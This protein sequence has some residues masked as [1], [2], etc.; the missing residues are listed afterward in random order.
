MV[1]LG[2]G[3]VV[4]DFNVQFFVDLLLCILGIAVLLVFISIPIFVIIILVKLIKT[5]I[6][7]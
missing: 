5:K 4:V 1:I 6:S 7:N 2:G 3:V